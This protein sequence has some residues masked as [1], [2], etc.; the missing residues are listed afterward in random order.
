MSFKPI[1]SIGLFLIS[2]AT[3]QATTVLPNFSS[4]ESCNSLNS[5]SELHKD[6][7][8]M[9][10]SYVSDDGKVDYN[11]F[12]KNES[13]LD[14]YLAL[15]SN[16]EPTSTWS[17]DEQLAFWINAY[18]AY[19][20]KLV[21]KNYP[22]NSITQL[23]NGKPWDNKWIK[24]GGQM[25]S[26][27]NI[28]NDIIRPQFNEPRIHFA[29]NCA[30]K[31]CPPILNEAFLPSKLDVQL[32]KVTIAF[33]NNKAFNTFD[34]GVACVSKIFEWYKKDFGNLEEYLSKYMKKKVLEVKYADYDWNLNK[35]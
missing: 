17:R 16:N 31:S 34:N 30:A 10:Q 3:V 22:I 18:N 33:L 9:L 25:Y 20:I 7:D 2:F 23:D 26:L 15:L 27:N 11:A 6:W 24:I 19:T 4:F 28:E 5:K 32:E 8:A 21:V 14:T 1:I 12:K 29:V 35:R 13:R